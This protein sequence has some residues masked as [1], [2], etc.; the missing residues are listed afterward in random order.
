MIT[1]MSELFNGVLKGARKLPIIALVQLTFYRVNN[2]FIVRR[3]HG[4]SRLASGHGSDY[5]WVF[6]VD[7]ISTYQDL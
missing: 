1:N 5:M 2:Y 7:H 6:L 3:E 4:E